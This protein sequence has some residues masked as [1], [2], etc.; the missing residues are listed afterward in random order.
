MK[1]L[2]AVAMVSVALSSG[3]LAQVT[4]NYAGNGNGGFGGTVGQSPSDLQIENLADGTLNF[5]WTR[6]PGEFN[7]ALVLYIDSIPGGFTDTLGFND[8][9]DP[10]R[11]AI[12]GASEGTTG[13][14]ANSRSILSFNTGFEADYAFA[15]NTTFGGLWTLVS[16]G[17]N[18]LT[19]TT[20]TGFGPTGNA[21]AATYTWS[22]NVADIGLTA[23]SGQSFDFVGTYLNASNSFR[24]DEAFGFSISGG[25]PGNGG[26]GS[27]PNTVAGSEYTFQT[28]PEPATF[29]LLG[30]AGAGLAGHILYR[31]WRRR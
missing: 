27:Y 13:S 23:N 29:G 1:N 5:S 28:V 14:D 2:F 31:R 10:L 26:I 19:F 11:S 17:D 4:S 9:A 15:A 21:T 25:N 7:D 8:Q 30:M 12:S 18:S 24:S 3:A 20:T 6:G 22:F 16:G